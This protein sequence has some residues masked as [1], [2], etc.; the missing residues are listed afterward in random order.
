M[1]GIIRYA[2]LTAVVAAW[3]A[4]AS[5]QATAPAGATPSAKAR[6][7]R[8]IDLQNATLNTRYRFID[9]PTGKV[10]TNQQQYR[11]TLR[12]RLKFD[13]AARYSL[14]LG[15]FTGARFTSG[16]D[17][18]GWG[19][20]GAQKNLALKNLYISAAPVKG[21]EGQY[22]SLYILKGESTE[23]TTYDEDGYVTGER[24]SMR[25]P[26][27]LYFDEIDATVGYLSSVPREIPF[28]RRVK[29][30]DDAPNYRHVLVDKRLSKRLA[31]STD[32]T[33]AVG[34]HTWREAANVK[35]SELRVV[36]TL[37]FE[38]YERTN[39]TANYGFA[40]SLDKALSKKVGVNWGYASIDP[41]FGGLNADRFNT[42]N[43]GFVTLTYAISPQFQT[44][45]FITT[46]IGPNDVAPA[47][48]TL[49]N[50]IFTYNALPALR[51][52]GLF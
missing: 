35:V 1:R 41:K 14:N 21:I 49:M 5:A 16:W 44:S 34:A 38:N 52:T 32:F 22:G 45:Y 27:N 12:A 24:L 26:A 28:S 36:D 30:L 3:A 31:V 17:N 18:T 40:L 19:L 11:G 50:W 6:L 25:R 7:A 9:T 15:V 33:D 47:H 10:N 2:M 4:T 29:Y 43:R 20:A 51:R 13:K 42:G 48:R 23:I 39:A 8:W 37:I 46:T